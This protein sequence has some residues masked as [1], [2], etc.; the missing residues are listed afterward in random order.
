MQ[1][2]IIRKRNDGEPTI[3]K[4][5]KPEIL[6]SG[7]IGAVVKLP[8]LLDKGDG[9]IE[10]D[11]QQFIRS[12]GVRVIAVQDNQILFTKE[13]RNELNSFDYR[14]PGGKVFDS[15]SEF[16]SY[17]TDEKDVPLDS[18]LATAKSELQEESAKDAHVFEHF[19]KSHSG[20]SI[21]WDLHYIIAR[22]IFDF[23]G[24]VKNEG[25]QIEAVIWKSFDEVEKMC[26]DGDIQEDRTVAALLQFIY[27]KQY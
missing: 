22:D 23:T 14:L 7:K 21:D 18:I 11:F 6:Y 25:E 20:A 16:S 10:K 17:I 19:K 4:N 12:P 2:N 5:G 9:Y 15:F 13:Y 1:N 26:L 27:K 3:L 8:V 24:E